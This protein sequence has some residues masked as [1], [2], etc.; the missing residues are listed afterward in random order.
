[1]L[2]RSHSPARLRELVIHQLTMHALAEE[3]PPAQR[4][5]SLELLGKIT[6][7]GAFTERKESIVVHQSA[8]LKAKLLD[9][10]K[11]IVNED[12]SQVTEDEGD[13]LLRELMG[14]RV[15]EQDNQAPTHTAP[16]EAENDHPQSYKHTNPHTQSSQESDDHTESDS[17]LTD[18]IHGK[19][20]ISNE[21]KELL[22]GNVTSEKKEG[23]GVVEKASDAGREE[24]KEVPPSNL[25][26]M[27]E[28]E[29]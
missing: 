23:V 2:F 8:Q 24:Y 12:G 5:K 3:I 16:P 28:G 4:I 26:T 6:E 17:S 21:N 10:L 20:E 22:T 29:V 7:V 25:G 19:N 9:Q 18:A 27:G 14:Y 13:K 1:M 15:A 11:T